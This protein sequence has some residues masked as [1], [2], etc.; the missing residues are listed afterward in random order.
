MQSIE[1][2]K[3]V[4]SI[5]M[6]SELMK[7]NKKYLIEIDSKLGDGD[8]GLT[9]S[10]A[11]RAAK[12]SAEQNSEETIGNILKKAGIAMAMAAPSTMGTLMATAFMAAGEELG[13]AKRIGVPQI[14]KI[15]LSMA[16]AVA[17]RGKAQ[18]GDKTL[19][20]VLYPVS[21]AV[22][23]YGDQ[24][25]VECMELA[26]H[27]ARDGMEHTKELMNQ[28]GKAAVFREKSLGLVDPG[29]AAAYIM[30][31]GFYEGFI[32]ENEH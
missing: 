8:L 17:A 21:R 31:E 11:F 19:L 10:K 24:D 1:K 18:E 7:E 23:T 6:I 22:A 3:V 26:Y 12:K 4:N 5:G 27:A 25:I 20:D 16:G 2:E 9:M 15:F 13:D 14:Q 29:A 30:I 28:H 32:Q